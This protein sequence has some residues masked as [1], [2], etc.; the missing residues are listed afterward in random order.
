M[1]EWALPERPV[2][3]LPRLERELEQLRRDPAERVLSP[4]ERPERER[5]QV[6]PLRAR[7]EEREQPARVGAPDLEAARARQEQRRASGCSARR[8][9]S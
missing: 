2:R 6:R 7:E 4:D 8:I 1:T 9:P 3:M 5:A